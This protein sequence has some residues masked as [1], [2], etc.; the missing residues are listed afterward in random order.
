MFV[1]HIPQWLNDCVGLKTSFD[2][3]YVALFVLYFAFHFTFLHHIESSYDYSR[4]YYI[5]QEIFINNFIPEFYEFLFDQISD[6][7]KVGLGRKIIADKEAR[8]FLFRISMGNIVD[9][10]Y[11]GDNWQLIYN[12]SWTFVFLFIQHQCQYH[13]NPLLGLKT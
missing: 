2:V 5:E 6:T 10:R 9:E 8:D 11:S 1:S 3:S 7:K 12:G 4:Y 13:G